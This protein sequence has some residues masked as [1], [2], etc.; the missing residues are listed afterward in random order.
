MVVV[1]DEPGAVSVPE[2]GRRLG[3]GKS[4]AWDL[5][6]RGELRSLRLGS[7]VVVPVKAIEALLEGEPKQAA[8]S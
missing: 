4:L 2:A 8:A 7:R 3:I 5:V 1:T 6:W